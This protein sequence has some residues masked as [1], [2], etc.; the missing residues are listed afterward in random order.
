MGRLRTRCSTVLY[1]MSGVVAML[2]VQ[3]SCLYLYTLIASGYRVGN[4][5]NTHWK[6]IKDRIIQED[7]PRGK[8]FICLNE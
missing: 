8:I 2:F 1:F 7:Y 6:N 3:L 5:E 4:F